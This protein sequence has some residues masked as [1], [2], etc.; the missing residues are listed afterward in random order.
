MDA[1]RLHMKEGFS[2]RTIAGNHFFRHT[3]QRGFS[4]LLNG[5]MNKLIRD[6]TVANLRITQQA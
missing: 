4:E 3:N 2:L 6:S 5:D 1:W